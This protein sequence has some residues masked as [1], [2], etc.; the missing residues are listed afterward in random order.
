[1][2]RLHNYNKLEKNELTILESYLPKQ[3][4]DPDLQRLIQDEIKA[5]GIVS[6]KD[7]GRLMKLLVEKSA[8]QADARR[9]SEM[10]GKLLV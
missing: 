3:M 5:A 6:K 10:L 2:I 4:S 9:V 8:G 1:M 7:F